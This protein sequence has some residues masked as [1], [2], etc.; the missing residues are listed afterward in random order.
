MLPDLAIWRRGGGGNAADRGL[1]HG[2]GHT[3]IHQPGGNRHLY[4]TQV[5]EIGDACEIR[6]G[7]KY[8]DRRYRFEDQERAADREIGTQLLRGLRAPDCRAHRR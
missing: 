4:P 3:Q 6:A 1:H 7:R 2:N 8:H 5:P